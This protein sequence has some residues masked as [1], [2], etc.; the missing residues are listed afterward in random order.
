MALEKH[1]EKK[2][3]NYY[4]YPRPE[5]LGY[6]P[7]H[8]KR[9]LDV[10][11]S[12]GAFGAAL[13][14]VQRCEV[15]GIEPHPSAAEVAAT[16]LDRVHQG[17]FES[18][19]LDL[20]GKFDCVVFN[21]VLEHLIDPWNVLRRTLPLLAEGGTVVASIPNIRH[22][23]TFVDLVLDGKWRYEE[24]GVLDRTHL[25]FFT[26]SGM[27]ALFEE[28]GYHVERLEPI[29]WTQFPMWLSVINRLSNR[30]FEDLHYAQYACVARIL[31]E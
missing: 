14:K 8:A 15:V 11:C 25:R 21:D 19:R 10:G 16:L 18:A 26:K 12:A 2:R 29:G 30:R 22:V 28:C 20:L 23:S 9:V 17:S 7:R 13:K 3:E 4:S 1:Y 27:R 5:M 6:I 24:S 31:P